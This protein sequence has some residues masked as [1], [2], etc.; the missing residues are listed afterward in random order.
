MV[1]KNIRFYYANGTFIERQREKESEKWAAELSRNLFDFIII[2]NESFVYLSQLILL[3]RFIFTQLE[4]FYFLRFFICSRA[5]LPLQFFVSSLFRFLS[6]SSFVASTRSVFYRCVSV[7]EFVP[8]VFLL[9]K[10]LIWFSSVGPLFSSF[11]IH[12]FSLEF[13]DKWVWTISMN[14]RFQFNLSLEKI[15]NQNTYILLYV[16]IVP[17]S[18]SFILFIVNFKELSFHFLFF[19]FFLLYALFQA[20]QNRISPAATK[21]WSI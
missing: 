8:G 21:C 15:K 10:I 13:T 20:A 3:M 2:W 17:F 16:I 14:V 11:T 19:F 12:K 5:R 6:R 9:C 7:C 4:Y 18:C 1:C